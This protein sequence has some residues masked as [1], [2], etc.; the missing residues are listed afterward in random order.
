MEPQAFLLGG[1][2]ISVLQIIDRWIAQDHSY[3]KVAASDHAR[4][5]LRYTPAL[6]QWELTLFQAGPG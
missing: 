6:Q 2:R 4:Y 1:E 3:Y 5:I